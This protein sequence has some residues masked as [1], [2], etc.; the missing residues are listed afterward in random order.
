MGES[1]ARDYPLHTA[2]ARNGLEAHNREQRTLAWNCH[3]RDDKV[4][5]TLYRV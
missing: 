5:S 2:R 1:P 4:P 3:H